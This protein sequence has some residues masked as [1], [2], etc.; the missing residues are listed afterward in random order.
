MNVFAVILEEMNR[1]YS[2]ILTGNDTGGVLSDVCFPV[3]LWSSL[4]TIHTSHFY[5]EQHLHFLCTLSEIKRLLVCIQTVWVHTFVI[6]FYLTTHKIL[7]T[8]LTASLDVLFFSLFIPSLF[9][10][11]VAVSTHAM[12]TFPLLFVPSKQQIVKLIPSCVPQHVSYSKS[13]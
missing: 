13:S 10:S 3:S 12:Y 11:K 9:F 2:F 8:R 1:L 6:L 4:I 7:K 5:F